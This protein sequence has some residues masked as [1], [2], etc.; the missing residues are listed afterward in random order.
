MLQPH[1]CFSWV[2]T[3]PTQLYNFFF[4]FYIKIQMTYGESGIKELWL[5][6]VEKIEQQ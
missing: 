1:V 3:T 5:V 2:Y 4:F 6:T